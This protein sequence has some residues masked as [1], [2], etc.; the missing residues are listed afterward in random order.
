MKYLFDASSI[1]N[2]V[3]RGLLRPLADGATLNL[4]AYE[5]VNAVWK[6]CW[7]LKRV[8]ERVAAEWVALLAEVLGAIPVYALSDLGEL[9][10]VLTGIFNLAVSE[11]VTV[12]DSSYVYAAKAKGLA[13]VTDDARLR[14]AARKHVETLTSAQ[15]LARL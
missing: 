10:E 3:K 11:G 7:L 4:A 14:G 5:A 8:S 1:V 9:G 12:Y 15:L 6:E 2:L 13:L